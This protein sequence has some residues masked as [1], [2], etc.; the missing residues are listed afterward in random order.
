MAPSFPWL[1]RKKEVASAEGLNQKAPAFKHVDSSDEL[2]ATARSK[3]LHMVRSSK[4]A[5]DGLQL[6]QGAQD[7]EVLTQL[8]LLD[9]PHVWLRAA[10][11]DVATAHEIGDLLPIALQTRKKVS[12]SSRCSRRALFGTCTFLSGIAFFGCAVFVI[13]K[14]KAGWQ[15]GTCHISGFANGHCTPKKIPVAKCELE[16]LVREIAMVMRNWSLPLE[17][18]YHSQRVVFTGEPFRCCD[19]S[20]RLSCCNLLNRSLMEFCDN[21]PH[22]DD[23][24]GKP[25]PAKPW[26]CQYKTTTREYG[27]EVVDVRA[28][29]HPPIW[30]Y[31]I[32]G[33]V[34]VFLCLCVV[35]PAVWK[36]YRSQVKRKVTERWKRSRPD[37]RS[38]RLC[39]AGASLAASEP[40][41]KDQA[42]RCSNAEAPTSG[43]NLT[44]VA[45]AC[46]GTVCASEC[47]RSGEP[48]AADAPMP[49]SVPHMPAPPGTPPGPRHAREVVARRQR[50]G[51]PRSE[52]EG[53][54]EEAEYPYF[55]KMDFT[56][57]AATTTSHL[58]QHPII[59]PLPHKPQHYH[60]SKSRKEHLRTPPTDTPVKRQWA[61]EDEIARYNTKHKGNPHSLRV[62]AGGVSDTSRGFGGV[63]EGATRKNA[64]N[65]APLQLHQQASQKRQYDSRG[66]AFAAAAV[67][68]KFPGHAR[69]MHPLV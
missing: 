41:K 45:G 48:A 61:N 5:M 11:Y 9:S 7:A 32:G 53:S 63:E 59:A 34:F 42:A 23:A 30:Y 13:V 28:Y 54:N 43:E 8:A 16:V 4:E 21:W 38:G 50:E 15:E 20:G 55:R 10:G 6:Q 65:T 33:S 3:V 39:K 19:L 26:R 58:L 25:C 12:A 56:T 40:P 67:R 69:S 22:L 66:A 24:S 35:M 1:G 17:R 27:E 44:G 14:S 57:L 64:T 68:D 62:T 49:P 47:P 51:F 29:F 37:S 60:G 36:R 2:R 31:L 18:D 46:D 52:D